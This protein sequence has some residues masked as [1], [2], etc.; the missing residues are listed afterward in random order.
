M[1]FNTA[2]LVLASFQLVWPDIIRAASPSALSGQPAN[3]ATT[4][5]PRPAKPYIAWFVPAFLEA[6]PPVY[7]SMNLI[8]S[9]NWKKLDLAR[10][11]SSR[12]V[13]VLKWAYGPISEYSKGDPAYY[14]RTC[15]PTNQESNFRFAGV[16]IDEWNTGHK[17]FKTERALA[18]EGY[19]RAR[20]TWPESFLVLWVIDADDDALTLVREG[21]VDLAIVEAYSFIPDKAG[22]S[23]KTLHRR[24]DKFKAA[25]LLD[26]VIVCFGYVQATPDSKGRRMTFEDLA[27]QVR[28]VHAEYPEMPGVA[29]YGAQRDTSQTTKELVKAADRLAAELF[30]SARPNH[31][32][33]VK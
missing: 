33:T 10:L 11:W 12:G 17:L 9:L 30:P 18:I 6:E 16:G 24:C 27:S 1:R 21:T 19:R 15:C 13:P 32:S 4:A 5:S 26:R 3:Q 23:S 29:F 7:H 8:T 14:E 2:L 25:G 20:K 28:T 31:R 22:V